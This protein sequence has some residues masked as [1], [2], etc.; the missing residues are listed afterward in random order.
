MRAY[1]FDVDGTLTPSRSTIDPEFAEWFLDWTLAE[2]LTL[3]SSVHLVTGSDYPKTVEQVGEDI[4]NAIKRC[5]NCSGSSVWEN[6][7]EIFHNEFKISEQQEDWLKAQ[8]NNSRF[9]MRTG[10]HFE[11]RTGMLNFSIVGRN[12]DKEERK[13]YVAY[14][15]RSRER[16]RIAE[17]FNK[18]FDDVQATVGGE[19]GLD[20]AQLGKDK[21]QIL[22]DF[23]NEPVTFFGDR[24]E[25][26]GNDYALS[27]ALWR[28]KMPDPF[29]R[30]RLYH[31]EDWKH[32]WNILKSPIN[33]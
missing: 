18:Q 33:Y 11:Y 25:E 13:H 7:K 9:H 23:D 31:V 4:V 21:S 17:Q 24:M 30:D 6:G 16:H 8:L 1:I 10:N 2:S 12:A 3:R 32:T 29:N 15:K 5:Y 27:E 22:R 19:T 26:G 28:R 20:I 14:D